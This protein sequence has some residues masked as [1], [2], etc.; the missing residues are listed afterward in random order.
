MPHTVQTW[1]SQ[2]N[3][4][5]LVLSFHRVAPR[6]QTHIL[7]AGPLPGRAI[8]LAHLRDSK[9]GSLFAERVGQ[10]YSRTKDSSE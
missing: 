5:G 10:G 8:S 2:E 6:D 7:V 9:Q 4:Q 1:R 3:L